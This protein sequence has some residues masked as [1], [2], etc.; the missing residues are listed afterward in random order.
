MAGDAGPGDPAGPGGG[1]D[2]VGDRLVG[3]IDLRHGM[4]V[5]AVAGHRAEYRPLIRQIPGHRSPQRLDAS[6]L[7]SAYRD[8]GIRHFYVADLDGILDRNP[9]WDRLGNI[10]ESLRSDETLTIDLGWRGD[11]PSSPRERLKRLSAGAAKLRWVAAAESSQGLSG[12]RGLA[13]LVGAEKV[14][15][16]MDYQAGRWL[17]DLGESVWVEQAASGRYGGMLVL[18]LAG[19]GGQGGPVTV[20]RVRRLTGLVRP[21]GTFR[22]DSGGGIRDVADT[23]RLIEAGCG[24]CLVATAVHRLVGVRGEPPRPGGQSVKV[25][26]ASRNARS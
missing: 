11:E 14:S 12:P 20:G 6:G 16:G 26:S 23:R 13:D 10:V 3:V 18:D 19:V 4:P 15:L 21:S 1:W 2:S 7:L 24:G 8:V 22:I 9:R 17:G 5:H 25:R